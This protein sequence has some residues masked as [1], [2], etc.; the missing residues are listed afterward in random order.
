MREVI[1]IP[2][3]IKYFVEE[4][5]SGNLNILKNIDVGYR[6]SFIWY[7]G[8][9]LIKISQDWEERLNTYN[10]NLKK[11]LGEVEMENI[12]KSIIKYTKN[13]KNFVGLGSYELWTPEL[14]NMYIKQYQKKK[15]II[16]HHRDEW[17]EINKTKVLQAIYKLRSENKKVSIRRVADECGLNKNTVNKYFKELK[18]DARFSF[19]FEKK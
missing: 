7:L 19:L 5:A 15:G 8:M 9:Y 2:K 17:Y 6:N 3:K 13:N 18:A 10:I 12:K 14:K 16:K 1:F 11:P 4:V